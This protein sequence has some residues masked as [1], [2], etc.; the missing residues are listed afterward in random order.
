MATLL[1]VDHSETIRMIVE[2][3]VKNF[4]L[5]F[6]ETDSGSKGI[7]KAKEISDLKYLLLDWD[8]PGMTGREVL[9]TIRADQKFKDVYILLMMNVDNKHHVVDALDLG[10]NNYILKPFSLQDLRQKLDEIM[11]DAV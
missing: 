2:D 4:S 3:C 5:D 11:H 1:C 10:A 8:T 6:E 9:K 7:E